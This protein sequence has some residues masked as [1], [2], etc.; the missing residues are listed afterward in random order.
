MFAENL[1]GLLISVPD[2]AITVHYS[3]TLLMEMRKLLDLCEMNYP[4][5]EERWGIA[6]ASY[7]RGNLH[8]TERVYTYTSSTVNQWY[9]ELHQLK[10]DCESIMASAHVFS[11][12][13]K[14][15]EIRIY[16][17][18]ENIT[19]YSREHA[20][21][22]IRMEISRSVWNALDKHRFIEAIHHT[23]CTLNATY[24]S[25]DHEALSIPALEHARFIEYSEN[26]NMVDLETCMPDICWGQF[27]TA[28][29]INNTASFNALIEAAPCEKKFL[30][31]DNGQKAAW[32]QLDYD[33]W[34]PTAESRMDLRRHFDA[35]LPI[36]SIE[37]MAAVPYAYDYVIDLM[38]LWPD[39][40]KK[41]QQL[42]KNR[43]YRKF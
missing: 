25:I 24:A 34:K 30:V 42:R 8:S 27:I 2:T 18:V 14:K 29:R 32:L 21:R 11:S 41:L 33:I 28:Q 4:H 1:I 43:T 15:Y 12:Q 9:N 5:Y 17:R 36:L 6:P 10:Q 20:P 19:M 35:S 7:Y 23:C 22:E 31:T 38:P 26:Q 39:E 16:G 13:Q 40:R 37:K 3:E